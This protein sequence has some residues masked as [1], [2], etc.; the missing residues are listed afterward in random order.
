[1]LVCCAL[2][3]ARSALVAAAWLLRAGI[4]ATTEEAV[5]QVQKARPAVVLGPP[6]IDLLRCWQQQYLQPKS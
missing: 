6:Q 3:F 2:G 4:A 1:M 5:A